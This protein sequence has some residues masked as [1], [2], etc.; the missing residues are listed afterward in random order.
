MNDFPIP[1]DPPVTMTAEKELKKATFVGS[2]T[3]QPLADAALRSLAGALSIRGEGEQIRLF[4][5]PLE[6]VEAIEKK[7]LTTSRQASRSALRT[8]LP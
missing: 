7:K 6:L 8:F 5:T 1:E 2:R 3:R 4:D